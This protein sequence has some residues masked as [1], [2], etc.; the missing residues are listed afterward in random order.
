MDVQPIAIQCDAIHD[1]IVGAWLAKFQRGIY[2]KMHDECGGQS[3][4]GFIRLAIINLWKI[5]KHLIDC[6]V[7]LFLK[8]GRTALPH[9]YAA[10]NLPA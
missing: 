1:S 5:K 6:A 2:I 3:V 4:N 10:L 9:C 8:Q 7:V